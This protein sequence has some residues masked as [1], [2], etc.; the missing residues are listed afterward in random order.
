MWV[1]SA[2][3]RVKSQATEQEVR[4]WAAQC[5]QAHLLQPITD[6]A[7]K[8]A[9]HKHH[10]GRRLVLLDCRPR[11]QHLEAKFTVAHGW[12]QAIP[13]DAEVDYNTL[14]CCALG[15][16]AGKKEEARIS[17]FVAVRGPSLSKDR[18]IPGVAAS[19][20]THRAM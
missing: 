13:H 15:G 19:T 14:A 9:L 11:H 17:S 6:F 1:L 18:C 12:Q 20:P 2:G 7:V 16:R 8:Y 4:S 10:P 5:L 3:A